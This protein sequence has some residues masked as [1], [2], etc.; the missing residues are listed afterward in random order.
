MLHDADYE[1]WPE[2]HARRV[3][4]W[5]RACG[6]D[7]IAHAISAHYTRWNVPHE[8]LLD[9]ALLASDELAGFVGACALVRPG[10]IAALEAKSVLEKLEDNGFAAEVERA[11]IQAGVD[12]LGVALEEHAAFVIAALKPH[13][14]ELRL[15]GRPA[16]DGSTAAPSPHQ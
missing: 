1:A 14:A 3:V 5:L 9:P 10:G 16:A 12:P 13:A 2:E 7:E 8:T 11:E 6:E 4:A 15:Q